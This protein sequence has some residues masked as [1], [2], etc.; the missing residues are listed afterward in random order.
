MIFIYKERKK[1]W[2]FIIGN[3]EFCDRDLQKK[4]YPE[5][6]Q[7]NNNQQLKLKVIQLWKTNIAYTLTFIA[8]WFVSDS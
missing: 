5:K 3:L 6:K 7:Y 8:I 4:V 2:A 1:F